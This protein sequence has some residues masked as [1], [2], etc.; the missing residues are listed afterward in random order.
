VGA[1][2]EDEAEPPFVPHHALSDPRSHHPS[3]PLG[4]HLGH[5]SGMH[6]ASRARQIAAHHVRR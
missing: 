5:T 4:T 6:A 2:D 1:S 3:D